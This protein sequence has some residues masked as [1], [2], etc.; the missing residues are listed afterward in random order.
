ML[1]VSVVKCSSYSANKISASLSK[2]LDSLG[3]FEKFAKPGMKV[4]LKVNLLGAFK[5]EKHVTTN[6]ALLKAVIRLCQKQKC[7]VFVGDSPAISAGFGFRDAARIAG[8]EKVCKE[9]GAKFVELDEPVERLSKNCHA[10]RRL[11]VSKKLEGFDLI[12]N[13]PKLKTHVFTGYTGAVKNLYGCVPKRIKGQYHLRFP[14]PERFSR[15]L[16]DLHELVRPQLSIMDAVVGME[17][18][19][20]SAGKPKKIGLLL[21]SESCLA[22]DFVALKAVGLDWREIPSVFLAERLGLIDYSKVQVLGD[23]ISFPAV[24]DFEPSASFKSGFNSARFLISV[25]KPL[26]NQKPFLI[27]EKCTSC[28]KCFQ[29]CP[30]KAIDFR[31]KKPVFDYEKCIRCFCCHEVCP[32]KAIEIRDSF[33][34]GAMKKISGYLRHNA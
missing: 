10:A 7:K 23:S 4:L 22:L 28:G 25:F 30:A 11:F 29:V 19:G 24:K 8:F 1:K 14:T 20:P 31:T 33:L 16:L 21:A 9:T 5:P 27:P 6:P 26:L 34:L 17:G 18:N 12:I 15:M 3:G 13:L 32:E 2:A